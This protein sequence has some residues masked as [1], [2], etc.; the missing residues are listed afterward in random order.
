MAPQPTLTTERL[1][2]R[3]FRTD[4]APVVQTLAGDF[5]VADT[6]LNVP[7]PYLDGMAEEW[8]AKHGPAWESG[9]LATFAITLR[10]AGVVGAISLTLA[11]THCRAE[12]GYWVGRPYW[13]RGFAT[14][15][16]SAILEFGFTTLELNRIQAMHMTRNPASGRVLQKLGMRLEG[17]HRQY[18]WKTGRPEDLARYALLR[19]NW[20]GAA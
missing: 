15:A 11:P 5:A 7:H 4:D 12:L 2:L 13:N 6:T 17:I 20:R 8:I 10:S 1:V 16:A 14:E 9:A 3:P 18:Y 19:E